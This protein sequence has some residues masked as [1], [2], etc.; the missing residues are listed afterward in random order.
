MHCNFLINDRDATAEDIE[1][2]GE[3]VRARVK[4]AVGVA[5]EWEIIR[6]GLPLAGHAIGEA[7]AETLGGMSTAA[8]RKFEHVAVL[9]GGWSAEREVSLRSGAA[10]AD[11]TGAVRLSRHAHRCR[12]RRR[13]QARRDRSRTPASTRCTGAG[14]RTARCRASSNASAFPIRTP[15]CSPP[16]SPC[17]RA[18]AKQVMK[19]AGVSVS[20]PTCSSIATR[21]RCGT[22]WSRPT[23]PSRSRRAPASA[24]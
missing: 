21:R 16:R 8:K 20:P 3:T 6:L 5:L 19:A 18:R 10:C 1:R 17:T 22:R 12:P 13:R 9:M 24:S 23:W 14:A 15:A 11:G 4:A 7:L 2:L